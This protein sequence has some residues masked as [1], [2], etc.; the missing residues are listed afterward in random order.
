MDLY[1]VVDTTGSARK[2]TGE[3]VGNDEISAILAHARFAPNGGNRQGWHVIVVRENETRAALAE[4]VARR[5]VAQVA[6][7]EGP[8]NT[9]GGIPHAPAGRPLKRS[10]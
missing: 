10:Q 4:P 2:F 8:W 6:A 7:G 9:R 1:Q 5:Y 3:T